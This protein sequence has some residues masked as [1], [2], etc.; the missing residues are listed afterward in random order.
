MDSVQSGYGNMAA[1]YANQQQNFG[2]M[3]SQSLADLGSIFENYLADREG[4]EVGD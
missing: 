1:N 4:R 3:A 2:Q